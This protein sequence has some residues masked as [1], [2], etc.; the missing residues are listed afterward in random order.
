MKT[1]WASSL[2]SFRDMFHILGQAT[3]GIS[4]RIGLLCQQTE[5]RM[6]TGII[7]TIRAINSFQDFPWEV[8][9]EAIKALTGNDEAAHI[10][11]GVH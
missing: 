6:L 4:L 2:E 11:D 3:Q 7:M 9:F 1:G 8:L 5:W 10:C